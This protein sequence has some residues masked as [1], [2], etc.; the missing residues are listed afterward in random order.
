MG[1]FWQTVAAALLIAGC[2]SADTAKTVWT[3][4]NEPSPMTDQMGAVL[5]SRSTKETSCHFSDY[6]YLVIRCH[7]GK[8]SVYVQ[9]NCFVRAENREVGRTSVQTRSGTDEP[10][11]QRIK[12]SNDDRAFGFWDTD[13][14]IQFIRLRLLDRNRLVVRFWPDNAPQ[15]T[16]VFNTMHLRNAV[17]AASPACDWSDLI[18]TNEVVDR[19][20]GES[21]SASKD[22]SADIGTCP[23]PWSD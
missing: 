5:W 15:Q 3:T 13:E 11:M 19:A 14:A 10:I 7:E 2:A 21:G 4:K 18:A 20:E 17:G 9:H 23:M 8:T 6:A 22:C 16:V 12:T 1:A